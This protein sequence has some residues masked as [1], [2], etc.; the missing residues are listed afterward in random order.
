MHSTLTKRMSQL[1]C[2]CL[3]I[4]KETASTL[5]L[6]W[7]NALTIFFKVQELLPFVE[8]SVSARLAYSSI[9]AVKTS[10]FI[11][12]RVRRTDVA[13][14]ENSSKPIPTRSGTAVWSPAIYHHTFTS[15]F[16]FRR[17]PFDKHC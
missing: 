13:D 14:I 2:L 1:F 17:E 8:I 3:D 10:F 16:T 11:K 5:P 15:P 4:K 6:F 12:L 9:L 7:I